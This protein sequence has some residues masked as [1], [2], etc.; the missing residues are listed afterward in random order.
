M[1]FDEQRSFFKKDFVDLENFK[2]EI[3][4]SKRILR[5]HTR[6]SS[7]GLSRK[8]E[9]VKYG[10]L[11]ANLLGMRQYAVMPNEHEITNIM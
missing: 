10:I 1:D 4:I 7:C 5:L 3:R 9:G 11:S 2:I 8:S 6:N